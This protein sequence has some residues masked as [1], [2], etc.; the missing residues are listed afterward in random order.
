MQNIHENSHC[1]DTRLATIRY[2]IGESVSAGTIFV[3]SKRTL[4]LDVGHCI[5]HPKGTSEFNI[6]SSLAGRWDHKFETTP[7]V[8]NCLVNMADG[9][10]LFRG[11]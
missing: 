3:S 1:C 4:L 10:I 9:T 11:T 2:P 5:S 6:L 8:T 7:K